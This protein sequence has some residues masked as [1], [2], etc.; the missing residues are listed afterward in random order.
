[1][2]WV[3][4]S[5]HPAV[6]QVVGEG[7]EVVEAVP[8]LGR[9]ERRGKEQGVEVV[10]A[11]VELGERGADVAHAVFLEHP[12]HLAG[13]GHDDLDLRDEA[14]GVGPEHR[15]ALVERVEHAVEAT[16]AHDLLRLVPPDLV[17]ALARDEGVA[18]RRQVHRLE[19]RQIL[20]AVLVHLAAQVGDTGGHAVELVDGGAQVLDDGRRVTGLTVE[21]AQDDVL[22]SHVGRLQPHGRERQEARETRRV[23]QVA[24]TRL[25]IFTTHGGL[26][27]SPI[28][29]VMHENVPFHFHTRFQ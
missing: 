3:A 4:T 22:Q 8:Q 26:S 16:G 18:D 17:D 15:D 23:L 20:V 24:T 21:L 12:M 11:G 25:V 14:L 6:R 29:D 1:M 9:D 13:E 7:P 5:R 19:R 27:F 10:P 2:R 28:G